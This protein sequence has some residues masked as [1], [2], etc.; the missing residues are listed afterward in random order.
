MTRGLE[1]LFAVIDAGRPVS[2][3]ELSAGTGLHKA[4]VSR[5]L[6]TLAELDYVSVDPRTGLYLPGSRVV[7]RLRTSQLESLLQ[8]YAMP[9]MTELRDESSE[10]VGLYVPVWPDRVCIAEVASRLGL[11][12]THAPGET[13]PLTVGATGLV[14][15]AHMPDDELDRLVK[16]RPLRGITAAQLRERVAEVR[17]SGVAISRTAT[18][19][20][21][22]LGMAAAI[23]SSDGRPVA[24]LTVSGPMERW[25]PE[26]MARFA[27]RLRDA[28]SRLS[29]LLG[30]EDGR[31][32]GR[33]R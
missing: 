9:I 16:V 26:V 33:K 19:I 24:M 21:G 10:T 18:H 11:R 6:A 5:M 14:Y 2:V 23:L 20:P 17:R 4:T 1:I 7:S 13:W 29:R 30:Y 25:N 28:V 3:T 12:R 27:P 8:A 22:M 32:R 31:V 15:L